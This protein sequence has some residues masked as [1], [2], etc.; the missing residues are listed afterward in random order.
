MVIKT[1]PGEETQPEA[2]APAEET[3][4]EQPVGADGTVPNLDK[5]F[6]ELKLSDESKQALI[7]LFSGVA[8]QLQ[9]A[10]TR[11]AELEKNGARPVDPAAMEG[12]TAEQK[13]NIIMA[14]AS[15][16]AAAAQTQMWQA[17]L[18]S[19]VGGTNKPGGGSLLDNLANSAKQLE[20]LRSVL[21]P[22][23]SP[24]ENAM[25]QAMIAQTLANARLT[26]R[27]AGKASTD[28][29][30]KLERDL[31]TAEPPGGPAT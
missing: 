20:V 1:K 13:Y 15:A 18:S 25:N 29:L 24:V 21:I 12:L 8:T 6:D 9:Q 27:I 2:E 7:G 22:A 28:L 4:A 17:L 10:N 11:L 31:F 3:K 23:A 19:G 14:R 30:D 16:P 26:N 5:L